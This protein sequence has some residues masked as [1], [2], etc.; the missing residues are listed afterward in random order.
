[1]DTLAEWIWDRPARCPAL[2]LDYEVYHQIR[3]NVTDRGYLQDFEDFA[4]VKCVPYVDRATLDRRM[5]GYV[6]QVSREWLN[7]PGATIRLD[8]REI[9]AESDYVA[10]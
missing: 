6:R 10:V 7:S 9:L 1:M 3:R 8:L 4:H 2:R 5:A